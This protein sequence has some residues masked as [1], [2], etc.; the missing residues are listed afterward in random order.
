[1]TEDNREAALKYIRDLPT[2]AERK[3]ARQ[4]LEVL[5]PLTPEMRLWVITQARKRLEKDG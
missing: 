1:M 4:I 2:E 3:A 5:E